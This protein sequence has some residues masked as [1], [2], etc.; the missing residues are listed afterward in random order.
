MRVAS[1]L[2][3]APAPV[4]VSRFLMAVRG[5]SAAVLVRGIVGPAFGCVVLA[6]QAPG[7]LAHE[8][9]VGT[10]LYES[11]GRLIVRT[12]RG[13]IVDVS[14]DADRNDF[15]LLCNEALRIEEFDAPSV[16]VRAD[17]SLLVGTS[18]GLMHI[19]SSLCELRP[20]S[21][22]SGV[23]VTA[24]VRDPRSD[25]TLYAATDAGLYVSADAGESFA[26]LDEHV[27][28]SLEAPAAAPGR[29]YAAGRLPSAPTAARAY[30]ASWQ[31]DAGFSPYNFVLEANEFGVAL[32]GSD[33]QA[34]VFAVAR[35]YLGTSYL[36]RLLVSS[37]GARS[38]SS[39][40]S[41]QGIA[42]FAFEPE[43]GRWYVGAASGLWRAMGDSDL[44]EKVRDE[45][46]S[47]LLAVDKGMYACDGS[48]ASGGVS[49]TTDAGDHWESILRFDEVRGLVACDAAQGPVQP[50]ASAWMDWRTELV[51][52]T[53]SS[54]ADVAKNTDAGGVVRAP[55]AVD[56]GISQVD[57][58]DQVDQVGQV[59][60]V[61]QVSQVGK[62]TQSRRDATASSSAQQP[63]VSSGPGSCAITQSSR[64]SRSPFLGLSITSVLLLCWRRR[65]VMTHSSLKTIQ[66]ASVALLWLA[67]CSSL[68]EGMGEA[69]ARTDAGASEP[70][71]AQRAPD[72]GSDQ[73]APSVQPDAGVLGSQA[74]MTGQSRA[75][76]DAGAQAQ[77][78]SEASDMSGDDGVDG[79]EPAAGEAAGAVDAGST[80][81]PAQP[82]SELVCASCG[83]CEEVQEVLSTRHTTEALTYSDPPPT[84][85]PHNPC[86]ASWG[87]HDEPTPAERWVHNLEHGAV[88]FL[89]N[90]PEGC[91]AEVATLKELAG[92][93]SFTLLTAY[94]DLPGR[95]AVVSWGHRLV[96]DCVDERAFTQF[97]D[98]NVNHAPESSTGEPN[99]GCPP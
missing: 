66:L 62:R 45:D 21:A 34:H 47:C 6:S 14:V 49:L 11:D 91:D 72:G 17:G 60:Q 89:Y 28:E 86:W 27:V 35:A 20:L 96:T 70:A 94:A 93:R 74:A 81:E 64:D 36:D 7:V 2:Q 76:A 55:A 12:N 52:E 87:I 56:S 38:F 10:A 43:Q 88:V 44:F 1:L 4:I 75:S 67:S 37:D 53:T 50:C 33:A 71:S 9:P 5:L 16:A 79:G 99:P 63:A 54:D 15:R 29:L 25:T 39:P 68:S 30:F 32:L 46:V 73:D 65:R 61:G 13:L 41:T 40:L 95:F 3:V 84:S 8:P 83:G 19:S 51:P 48:G 18:Q 78:S 42:A 90:C 77:P 31:K 69:S 80:S 98:N 24:L 22:L 97:Y 85:G 26:L 82:A 57:Q 58:T 92:S 23:R 59:G